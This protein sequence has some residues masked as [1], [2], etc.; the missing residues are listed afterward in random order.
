MRQIDLQR[1]ADD[2]PFTR[3]HWTVLIWCALAIVFDG[4]DL[5][6]VGIA[7]PSI[8]KDM[9]VDATQAGFMASSALFGMMFGN[10][11]FGNLSDR[12][13]KRMVM[14]LCIAIF[15]LFTAAAG[16]MKDPISFS[17]MRF[18]AGL[19]IGG[20]MPNVIAQMTDYSPLRMR[21]T[22]ITLTFSGYS[23]GGMLAAILGKGLIETYGWQ[24]VFLAAAAP[25]VLLPLIWWQM[26]ES[27]G[28]LLKKGRIDDL[29]RNLQRMSPSY[30][31]RADDQ[32]VLS[33]SPSAVSAVKK[34]AFSGLFADGRAF[35]T[36]MFWV[37]CFMALFMVYAL[38]S[39]LTK[40][41]A[42]AGYSLGSAL[43]F[44]LVLNI[45]A[46]LGA[47]FAGWLSDR[48]HIKLVTFLMFVMA[49]ISIT[50][51]G[52]KLPTT[53]LFVI[54]AIAGACTIG[55]QTMTCAYCSQFYPVTIRATGV[56]MMLGVGRA[57]AILA[58]IVIGTIVGMNLSLQANFMA[59]A[60]PAVVAAVT[61]LLIQHDRSDLMRNRAAKQS[62]GASPALTPV[63]AAS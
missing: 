3:F 26:P 57:G 36:V 20:V 47:V 27:L 17:A 28:Y 14:C 58:P 6:V 54:V 30:V 35:S 29:K 19:G 60:I 1:M 53:A 52:N 5:A 59:I 37:T 8:M 42:Q 44:V 15:S 2:A 10:M 16:L 23:V 40:L 11:I 25:V 56:G 46:T 51:M 45:G 13:G 12:F 7:L 31:P 48:M 41:M 43:T 63:G 61:I 34:S 9:G 49:A 55:T 38:N 32:F 33:A 62:E 21:S 4:Y 22:L 50:L 24:T 39:W 18:I